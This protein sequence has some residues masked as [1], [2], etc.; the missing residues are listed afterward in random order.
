LLQIIIQDGYYKA[1]DPKLLGN[2]GNEYTSLV[3]T[4]KEHI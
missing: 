2:T 4:Y 3:L 1:I